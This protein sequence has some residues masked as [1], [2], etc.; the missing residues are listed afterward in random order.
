MRPRRLLTLAGIAAVAA[1]LALPLL[2]RRG[3]APDSVLWQTLAAQICWGGVALLFALLL[4]GSVREQLGLTRSRLS[5]AQL[6]LCALGMLA[7]SGA[8]Q[9]AVDA[10]ALAPGSSLE[11]LDSIARASAPESPWLVLIAFGIA[12]GFGEELLFRG[13]V[14]RSLARGIGRWCI[15][16]TALAFGALHSDP[17]QSPA[18]FVLGC[19]LG[20]LALLA[21]STWVAIACHVVN[22]CAAVLPQLLPSAGAGLP[23]PGSWLEA[24]LWLAASALGLALIARSVRRLAP[25]GSATSG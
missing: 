10:L 15:P 20:S 4:G 25:P 17:V 1:P 21:D 3:S 23:R 22:N 16:A 19:Y 9:F 24:A 13:A 11:K 2:H 14:Q 6:A 7:L 8:L 12:P 18:A 5:L